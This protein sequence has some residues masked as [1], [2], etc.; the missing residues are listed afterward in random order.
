MQ[1][2]M[3]ESGVGPSYLLMKSAN[4]VKSRKWQPH[5]GER[6]IQL[7]KFKIQAPG[8]LVLQ[9]YLCR[10]KFKIQ[11]SSSCQESWYSWNFQRYLCRMMALGKGCSVPTIY[12]VDLPI[13]IHVMHQRDVTGWSWSLIIQGKT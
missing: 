6:V 12:Y 13:S 3:V 9:R 1:L 8:N 7:I 5:L 4:S 2:D 10:M 11:N